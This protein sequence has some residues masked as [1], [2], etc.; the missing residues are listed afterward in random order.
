MINSKT[1]I[2]IKD[3]SDFLEANCINSGAKSSRKGAKIGQCVKA[4]V[5]KLR[6]SSSEKSGLTS[7]SRKEGS[8]KHSLQNV[9]IVQTKAPIC[10]GDGSTIQFNSNSGVSILFKKAGLKKQH[11]LGFKRVN[12]AVSYELKNKI[13][14]QELTVISSVIKLARQLL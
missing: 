8:S 11:Q 2:L 4:S 6:V 1:K 14:A 3:N 9:L 10:R 12:T 13:Y 7:A 5:S